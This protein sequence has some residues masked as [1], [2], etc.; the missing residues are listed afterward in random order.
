MGLHCGD[1][2]TGDFNLHLKSDSHAMP[3][4]QNH[5]DKLQSRPCMP[6]T[7]FCTLYEALPSQLHQPSIADDP[8]PTSPH[9]Y[10]P[11]PPPPPP[12]LTI[13]FSYLYPT[14]HTHTHTPQTRV[15]AISSFLWIQILL[16]RS[17]K[18]SLFIGSCA[19]QVRFDRDICQ[20]GIAVETVG[21][22]FI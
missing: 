19:Q 11:S 21:Q 9:S 1:C 5:T 3:C 17:N 22:A 7:Q 10:L 13:T 14:P 12:L 20:E 8:P 4:E 2:S 16:S 18:K 6:P 15:S